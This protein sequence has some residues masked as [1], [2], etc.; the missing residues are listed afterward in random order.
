M[1]NKEE[2]SEDSIM[3]KNSAS[4][5]WAE[6]W[7]RIEENLGRDLIIFSHMAL[8]FLSLRICMPACRLL[9]SPCVS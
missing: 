7:R 2:N 6:A 8:C 3:S 4:G 1:N 9:S 5:L